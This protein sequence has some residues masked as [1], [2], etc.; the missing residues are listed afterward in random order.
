[1]SAYTH[2]LILTGIVLHELIK[3]ITEWSGPTIRY[4]QN[5]CNMSKLYSTQHLTLSLSIYFLSLAHHKHISFFS[6]IP[7]HKH[8]IMDEPSDTV[9]IHFVTSTQSHPLKDCPSLCCLEFTFYLLTFAERL[10]T[11]LSV[12]SLLLTLNSNCMD[13]DTDSTWWSAE[14][15]LYICAQLQGTTELF[16]RKGAILCF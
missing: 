9:M 1:M 16:S 10:M 5:C 2:A 15:I 7:A 3:S 12:V 8:W 11:A 4:A 6:Y 14:H 13:T